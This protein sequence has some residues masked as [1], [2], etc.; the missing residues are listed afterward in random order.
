MSRQFIR[1]NVTLVAILI[2]FIIFI[3]IQLIKPGFLYNHDGSIREFGIGYKN[4]TI[5]PLWLFSIILGI[6]SYLFVLYYLAYP[7][8]NL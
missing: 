6:F 2:F 7:K 8:I 1:N 4:K 3:P 5:M